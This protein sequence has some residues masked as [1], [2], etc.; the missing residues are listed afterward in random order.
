MPMIRRL[1]GA[2]LITWETFNDKG[3]PFPMERAVLTKAGKAEAAKPDSGSA[4]IKNM[5]AQGC[6][7]VPVP[8]MAVRHG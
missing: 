6:L 2:G 1:E 8:A 5:L 7:G 4:A 3:W